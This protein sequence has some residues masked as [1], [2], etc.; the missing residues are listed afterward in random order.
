MQPQNN[1]LRKRW[2][3]RLGVCVFIQVS[4]DFKI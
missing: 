1:S 2:E 4:S 3:F